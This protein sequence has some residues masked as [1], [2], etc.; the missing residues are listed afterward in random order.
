MPT[1]RYPR[2][3]TTVTR[4]AFNDRLFRWHEARRRPLLIRDATDP[5]QVLVAE[6]MSQQTG[7]ERVGPPW[8]RF[9]DRWPT[10]AALADAG[11]HEL[12]AAWARLGYNR[13]ALAL[14][15]CARTIVASHGGR[16]PSTVVELEALPG[17]GPYT[18]R[19]VAATAQGVPVAP[20]DVNV[21]RV[22]SRVLGAALSSPG[23]QEAADGLVSRSQPRRWLDA[24]MDLASGT[25]TP[26]APACASCPLAGLCASRGL[27]VGVEPK[28]AAPV[29]FPKTTRWLR[30]RLVAA[31]TA[32]P[33]GHW[34]ALPDHMG[35]HD[36][37]AI[38]AAARGLEREGFLDL[39]G[40]EARVR[41]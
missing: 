23:L 39:R 21:R 34:V 15:E 2:P 19:A 40:S 38:V 13:R 24:V 7:I 26:R 12:L 31:V 30:G 14:R 11:T 25:C 18:A 17:I 6:V 29:P 1:D 41:Q 8:R 36:A 9:V 32:A 28:G 22:V 33:A 16:V 35:D 3:V 4:R 27:A 10:P 5:W 37:D 20:L